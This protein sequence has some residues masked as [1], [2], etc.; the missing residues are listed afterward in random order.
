MRALFEYAGIVPVEIRKA[1]NDTIGI[2]QHDHA[3]LS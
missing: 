1:G 2:G 3:S